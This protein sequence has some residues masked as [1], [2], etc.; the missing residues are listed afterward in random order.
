MNATFDNRHPTSGSRLATIGKRHPM[1]VISAVLAALALSASAEPL[2][3]PHLD[4]TPSGAATLSEEGIL[5]IDA[6][7]GAPGGGASAR[8]DLR[9]L[10]GKSFRLT[11]SASMEGVPRPKYHYEGLKFQFSIYDRLLRRRAHVENVQQRFGDMPATT[12]ELRFDATVHDADEASLFLGLQNATGRARF[13]LSTLAIEE[14]PSAFTITNQDYIVRYPA[15]PDTERV[16]SDELRVTS[17]E[18]RVTSDTGEGTLVT[19]HSSLVTSGDMTPRRGVMSPGGD[20]TEGD[21]QTLHDWGATLLRFQMTHCPKEAVTN[22]PA[23]LE[24]VRGRLNHL[25]GVILPMAEKYGL[26]VVVD[27]HNV[28]GGRV[29]GYSDFALFDDDSFFEALLDLWREIA[30]RFKGDPRIYGYDFANEPFQTRPHKRDYWQVQNACAEAVRAIDPGA[31]LIVESNHMDSPYT[32][33]YL[34]PL[35][36]DDVVYSV[37]MYDPGTFTHQ[38]VGPG[39]PLGQTYPGVLESGG[40][41]L[42]KEWL[43]RQLAPVREFQLK[44]GARILVGEFSAI[45]WAR[46]ADRYIRDCIDI[47]EEYGWDWCYHAFREWKAWSVEHEGPD[48]D[49]LVPSADNPRKRALLDGFRK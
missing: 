25:E 48:R 45:A 38:G 28:P 5:E 12:L 26:K 27:L 21:F 34:S 31:T 23:Y 9:P 37:H 46:G 42:D 43:R 33:A 4:W 14:I 30:A 3:L 47:F 18:L 22:I 15:R 10:R 2:S 17:D 6:P 7:P 19:R 8:F 36:M 35:A 13:D 40:G 44:H 24:W 29:S 49:H 20:M 11:V 39:D 1:R 41:I 16:T 32:F